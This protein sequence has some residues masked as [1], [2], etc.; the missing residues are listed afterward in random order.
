MLNAVIASPCARGAAPGLHDARD[1]DKVTE[2]MKL[3]P[4]FHFYHPLHF[5]MI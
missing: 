5:H 2:D 1:K 3:K 4:I